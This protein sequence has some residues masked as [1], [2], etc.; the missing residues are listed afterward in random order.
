MKGKLKFWM[1]YTHRELK[2]RQE[3][4]RKR[5]QRDN[6][7]SS[8]TRGIERHDRKNLNEN[9]WENKRK[10]TADTKYEG[11]HRWPHRD[12]IGRTLHRYI[13]YINTNSWPQQPNRKRRIP[14]TPENTQEEAFLTPEKAD[15]NTSNMAAPKKTGKP[16]RGKTHP[17][18]RPS[19]APRNNH[20]QATKQIIPR[21]IRELNEDRIDAYNQARKARPPPAPGKKLPHML[22][23]L[24]EDRIGAHDSPNN[25]GAHDSP[26]NRKRKREPSTATEP[27]PHTTRKS[28]RLSSTH[29]I[30][31][32][33]NYSR[34]HGRDKITQQKHENI[35]EKN[36]KN[37]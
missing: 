6:K 21:M 19:L 7:I 2:H 3:T 26:N 14:L 24:H 8:R 20:K 9:L 5:Q 11:M 13:T 1:R 18:H 25:I 36:K 27:H 31:N 4:E 23:E 32:T 29:K 37:P 28:P 10:V 34:T 35:T 12:K 33:T 15:N 16:K 22:R 17:Y 30:N